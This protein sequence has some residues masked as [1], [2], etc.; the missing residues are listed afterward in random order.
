MTDPHY[1]APRPPDST[2]RKIKAINAYYIAIGA[3][4]AG[5]VVGALLV[6]ASMSPQLAEANK[7]TSSLRERVLEAQER[8]EEARTDAE[9]SRLATELE[10]AEKEAD[11]EERTAALDAREGEITAAEEAKAANEF[12]SGTMI[13]GKN[14][15]AGSYATTVNSGSCYYVWKDGTGADAN[16]IDNNIVESGPANVT[17]EDGQV[18][19]S[20]GCG[21]WTKQ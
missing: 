8:A 15:T 14:V 11:L 10:F 3:A 1:D 4:F 19:E 12:S 18:F 17:L 9:D 2:A 16:I 13:V 7:N 6:T 5:A 21:T 20:R